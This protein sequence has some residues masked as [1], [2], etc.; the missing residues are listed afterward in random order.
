MALDA[1]DHGRYTPVW[2]TQHP[3]FQVAVSPMMRGLFVYRDR[4]GG[5]NMM[6]SSRRDD[7]RFGTRLVHT[8]V[9]E[10]APRATPTSPP[11]Y[12]SS[13]YLHPTSEDLDRAF[14]EGGL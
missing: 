8:G 14:D 6:P 4:L 10:E 1:R 12:A 11:I 3:S 2:N 5:R 7:W 13:T 9:H